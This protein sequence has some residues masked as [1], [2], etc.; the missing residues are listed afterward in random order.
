MLLHNFDK[1]LQHEREFAERADRFYREQLKANQINRY[2]NDNELDMNFQHRDIDVSITINGKTYNVSEKFRDTDFGDMYVEVYSK[3]SNVLGW[4]HT[5]EP[6]FISYFTPKAVYLISH[7]NLRDFCINNLFQNIPTEF[8][9]EIFISGKTRIKK[10]IVIS[11]KQVEITIIQAHNQTG[12]SSW[13]T[14]GVAVDFDV[15]K[16]YNVKLEK[17]TAS[18]H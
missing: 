3:Y 5:G 6:D 7:K 15:L 11:G 9:E 10:Q 12:N 17:F 8:Y 14:I 13:K 1:S 18:S 4:I 2:N 16:M